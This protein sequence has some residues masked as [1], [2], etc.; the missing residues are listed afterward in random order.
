MGKVGV[1]KEKCSETQEYAK[2]YFYE[3]WWSSQVDEVD[4]VLKVLLVGL[5]GL[6]F[7]QLTS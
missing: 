1:L 3:C 6:R 4:E 5:V 7:F 2:I